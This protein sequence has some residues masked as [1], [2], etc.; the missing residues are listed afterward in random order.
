MA[1]TAPGST[2]GSTITSYTVTCG[3][4]TGTGTASPIA[5]TGLTNGTPYTCTVTATNGA[6]ASAASAAS[7]AATPQ[8][9]ASPW[10][11]DT[12]IGH[13]RICLCFWLVLR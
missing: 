11:Y 12:K 2:G 1:F 3:S 5:V 8:A 13:L 7:T 6:G 4:R 10:A 9:S